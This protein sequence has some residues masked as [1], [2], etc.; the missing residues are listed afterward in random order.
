MY[1]TG[2]KFHSRRLFN[3]SRDLVGQ[4]NCK[5][6]MNNRRITREVCLPGR[7]QLIFLHSARI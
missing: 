1:T 5:S 2:L 7:E 4:H 3:F 6:L